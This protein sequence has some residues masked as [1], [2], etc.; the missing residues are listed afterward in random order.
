MG[1]GPPYGDSH[2]RKKAG[3]S[4]GGISAKC[5]PIPVL[6]LWKFCTARAM[7]Q[8]WVANS[9]VSLQIPK[10][11]PTRLDDHASVTRTYPRSESKVIVDPYL[12]QNDLACVKTERNSQGAEYDGQGRNSE[13]A[14]RVCTWLHDEKYAQAA[15]SRGT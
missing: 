13:K 10:Q 2:T 3:R 9:K 15:H 7:R 4:C 12:I 11:K 1:I 6:M 8:T 5:V 14:T